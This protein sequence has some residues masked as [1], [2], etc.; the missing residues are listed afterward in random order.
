LL[1]FPR[2]GV[3]TI[4]V[5]SARLELEIARA[6]VEHGSAVR[7]SFPVTGASM[8]PALTAGMRVT[9]E[10]VPPE[11][12]EPADLVCWYRAGP[13]P[14]ADQKVAHRLVRL[15]RDHEGD[16]FLITRGDANAFDDPP[17]PASRVLGRVVEVKLPTFT[18]RFRRAARAVLKRVA[19]LCLRL[20]RPLLRSVVSPR[21]VTREALERDAFGSARTRAAYPVRSGPECITR[22]A[23]FRGHTVA[24]ASLIRRAAWGNGVWEISGVRVS[25][26]FRNL[27]LATRLCGELVA[28]VDIHL[29]SREARS[30]GAPR[31]LLLVHPD[32]APAVR[33]YRRM[34]FRETGDARLAE[35]LTAKDPP[36]HR[37][38][39]MELSGARE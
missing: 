18:W 12:L 27:G 33:V 19:K 21:L 30:L 20:A 26:W 37:R 28:H 23:R 8:A 1:I 39:V 15:E 36:S 22:V 10:S 7:M 11:I 6:A 4:K 29:R 35:R 38:I 34:G 14:G 32:N 9:V 25:P 13:E 31:T 2:R 24:V 16:L 3:E 17:V 5:T